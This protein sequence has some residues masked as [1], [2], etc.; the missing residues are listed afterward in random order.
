MQPLFS[1]TR[2][3]LLKRAAAAAPRGLL[4][5]LQA[6]LTL[7]SSSSHYLPWGGNPRFG[8]QTYKVVV[9]GVGVKDGDGQDF[10]RPKASFTIFLSQSVKGKPLTSVTFYKAFNPSLYHGKQGANGEKWRVWG[11]G[12]VEVFSSLKC[13]GAIKRVILIDLMW[14]FV[15]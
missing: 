5:R 9:G 2:R 7:A 10:A 3:W 4:L 15:L 14:G 1:W 12:G 6:R 13:W 8:Q 11:R